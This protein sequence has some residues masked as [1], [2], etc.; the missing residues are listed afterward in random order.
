MHKTSSAIALL[1]IN[2]LCI[3]VAVLVIG[4]RP[5]GLVYVAV[6]G[7]AMSVVCHY[8]WKRSVFLNVKT[9]GELASR[10]FACIGILV[11]SLL[12]DS[13]L[14][15]ANLLRPSEWSR[16]WDSGIFGFGA[17]A[18]TFVSCIFVFSATALRMVL[19]MKSKKR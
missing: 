5:L 17:T 14:A 11:C 18:A 4:I 9:F 7:L 8:C 12:V 1:L 16:L 13:L 6:G 19:I 10:W 15:N 2:L 3:V